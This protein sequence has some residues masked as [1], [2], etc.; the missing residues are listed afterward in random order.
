MRAHWILLAGTLAFSGA[1]PANAQPIAR[2]DVT[3]VVGWFNANKSD[4]SSYNDWYNRSAYGG[5]ELGV[6]WTD[7]L[8]TEV[9]LAATSP[10]ELY[11]VQTFD[12][13]GQ[14]AYGSSEHRF[15]TRRVAAGQQ[16][17][18][19]RN[20]WAHPHVAVGV[21]LTWET[22]QQR[23]DPL[24]LFDQTSRTTRVVQEPRTVGPSTDLEVRPFAEIGTKLYLSR[25]AFFRPDLRLTFRRGVDEVVLRF[26]L[27]VD[28]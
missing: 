23:L 13:Q 19:L 7:H 18:F 24:V 12:I 8:K 28:F 14:Q 16:Y 15:S 27:G 25:R 3:G 1:A 5:I 26:G 20:A 4:V 21:D 6:Y 22:H 10:A 17:Q 2:A 9:E 11:S